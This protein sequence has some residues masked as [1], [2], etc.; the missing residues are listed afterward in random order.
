MSLMCPL[1]V[2]YMSLYCGACA[3][4]EI[5]SLCVCVCV[6]VCVR[7][8]VCLCVCVSHAGPCGAALTVDIDLLT[9]EIGVSGAT[10]SEAGSWRS[11]G[12]AIL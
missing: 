2:P 8:C 11:V 1:Y 5:G 6:C 9:V 4:L 12:A 3:T 10:S 7:V